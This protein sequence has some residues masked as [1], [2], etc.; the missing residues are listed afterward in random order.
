V[1]Y[2]PFDTDRCCIRTKEE[3][4]AKIEELG[5]YEKPHV[6]RYTYPFDQSARIYETYKWRW[7]LDENA[8]LTSSVRN[9]IDVIPNDLYP[10]RIKI[11]AGSTPP[12]EKDLILWGRLYKE[13]GLTEDDIARITGWTSATIRKGLHKMNVKTTKKKRQYRT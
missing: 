9:L 6:H 11:G 1:I 8:K 2:I 12:T 10:I 7:L 13:V 5:K 4:T 3:W